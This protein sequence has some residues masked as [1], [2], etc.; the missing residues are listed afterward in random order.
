[1]TEKIHPTLKISVRDNGM[2]LVPKASGHYEHWTFGSNRG[3]GYLGVRIKGRNYSVHRIVAETFIP[4]PNKYRTVD[5]IDRNP[6]NNNVVN[7]RWASEKMQCANQKRV[8]ICLAKYGVREC[9]DKKEYGR[10]Y[11]KIYHQK[12]RE[13]ILAYMREYWK[14]HKKGIRSKKDYLFGGEK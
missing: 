1:M 11:I 7:L 4:N 12:H 10:R 13:K 9:E 5:H 8:D 2:V 6:S 3:R 14:R